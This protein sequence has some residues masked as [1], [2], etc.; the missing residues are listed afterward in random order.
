MTL[1]IPT[2]LVVTLA[3]LLAGWACSFDWEPGSQGA[4]QECGSDAHCVDNLVCIDRRCRPGSGESTSTDQPDT[5]VG[6]PDAPNHI[7]PDAPNHI[8][9]DTPVI[10]E[11]PIPIPDGGTPEC[12]A[13]ETRCAS[14]DT[15]E[16]CIEIDGQDPSWEARDC[17]T[18]RVC[19]DGECVLEEQQ[20]EDGE[21]YNPITGECVPENGGNT[22]ECCPGGCGDH[23]I[24]QDCTCTDYDPSSC[25]YQDQ[26]C[27]T[28]GQISGGFVCTQYGEE[29]D[30]RCF[31]LCSPNSANPN[32]TCPEE[33]SLCTYEDP[34]D[35]NGI[36]LSGCAIGDTCAD[37]GMGCMYHGAGHPDGLCMP[38]NSSAEIGESCNPNDFF[39]CAD[40]GI[41][42][43]GTCQQSCRPFDQATTDC[44]DGFCMAFT[45]NIGMC[46]ENTEQ[47]DGSCTQEFTTCRGDA[48]GCFSSPQTGQ[49]TCYEFC[50]LDLDDHDCEP[51]YYCEQHDPQNDQLG[52][53]LPEIT[54]Q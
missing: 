42:V 13:G 27:E 22:G 48:T 46:A 45:D 54:T 52:M 37:D 24:C 34:N 7:E 18:D 41:C 33:N 19:V 10:T 32:Q 25:V 26:P 49:L 21:V 20:C 36:C 38:A 53:C 6:T 9:P 23:Q 16:R 3:L 47:E 1:R 35:P 14:D 50:R 31:G 28:E 39:D 51:N 11:G 17:P 43:G 8:E 2:L 12:V 15:M 40:E 30:L 44:T 5:D 29:S 4:G